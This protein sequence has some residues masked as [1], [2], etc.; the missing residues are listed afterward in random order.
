MEGKKDAGNQLQPLYKHNPHLTQY[1]KARIKDAKIKAAAV[2]ALEGAS[3]S[4][5][6]SPSTIAS[7]QNG[8][9]LKELSK[10]GRQIGLFL[11][12]RSPHDAF[13]HLGSSR[14]PC[15]NDFCHQ[16]YE[17]EPLLA[18]RGN[19]RDPASRW[20]IFTAE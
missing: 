12:R 17:G 19:Q 4:T 10:E 15:T 14:R 1:K 5:Q 9:L 18:A 16:R 6:I 7:H 3:A 11:R 13:Q 8:S 2:S 20:D